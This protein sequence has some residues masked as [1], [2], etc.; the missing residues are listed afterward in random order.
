M[1][2]AILSEGQIAATARS[3]KLISTAE[4]R[5]DEAFSRLGD[6][7]VYIDGDSMRNMMYYLDKAHQQLAAKLGAHCDAL[8]N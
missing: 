3:M 5:L 1:S 4:D 2:A 8:A 7:E 6:C